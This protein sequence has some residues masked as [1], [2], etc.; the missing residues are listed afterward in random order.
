MIEIQCKWETE[1]NETRFYDLL[2]D[3]DLS[4]T[5]PSDNLLQS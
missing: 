3:Q 4:L 1:W 5:K 2:R